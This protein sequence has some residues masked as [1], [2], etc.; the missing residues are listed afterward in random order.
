[1][2]RKGYD[3]EFTPPA[4]LD[5]KP[6]VE[7]LDLDLQA[8]D[9]KLHDCLIGYYL[10]RRIPFKVTEEALKKAWSPYLTEVMAD[11]QGFFVLHIPDMDFRRKLL[12]GGPIT[13]AKV[14]FILQQWR[15]GLELEKDTHLTVPVWVKLRNLPFSFWSAQAIG[16]VASAVGKP[17]YVD[18]RTEQMDMLAFARVCVEI[19]ADQPSCDSIL[20]VH[21]GNS[22]IVA[23]EYEW[24][25]QVCSKCGIF[26]HNCNPPAPRQ[27]SNL[28]RPAAKAPVSVVPAPV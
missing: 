24:R 2:L 9:P 27:A 8:A 16:K 21:N 25:P 26:G 19:T 5:D 4:F 11:G 15:P 18:H 3:L 23:V 17:L 28:R 1:V 13:V 22:R 6:M 7:L 20:L 14:P 12:E 10:G